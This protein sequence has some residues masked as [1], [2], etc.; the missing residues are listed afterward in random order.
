[1]ISGNLLDWMSWYLLI[2]LRISAMF[3]VSPVFGRKNLPSTAKILFSVLL[4]FILVELHPNTGEILYTNLL[5]YSFVCLK[6]IITGLILGYMTT[7]FFSVCFTAGQIID[8]QI[9]FGMVQMYDST[10]GEQIP[11][12]GSILNMMMLLAFFISDGHLKLIQIL[13]ST[14]DSI[15]VGH[16]R[17][18][19]ELLWTVLEMFTMTFT[20]AVSIALPVIAASFITELA[21]GILVRTAPQM[22]IFVIGLPVKIVVGIIILLLMVPAFMG[23]TE[24]VFDRFYAALGKVYEGMVQQ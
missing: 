20:L 7:L 12:V 2:L 17:L 9:G 13:S 19:P 3:I 11:V 8:M 1:M 22:N 21:L 24:G 14:F 16:V 5:S 6:E 10:S 15:P 23:L 4:S 18:A